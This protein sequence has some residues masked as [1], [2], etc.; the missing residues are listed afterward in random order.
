MTTIADR[1]TPKQPDVFTDF[2]TNLDLHPL[3]DDI[4]KV[5]NEQAIKQSIRTLILTNVGERFFRPYLGSNVYKSLFEPLDGFV[6]NDIK[7][8][9]EDTINAYEPRAKVISV[10]VYDNQDDGNSITATIQFSIINTGQDAILNL[11]LRRVR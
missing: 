11:I 8:Y 10:N 4:A 7:T 1:Y 5:K 9:I 2:M 6:Q 3:S